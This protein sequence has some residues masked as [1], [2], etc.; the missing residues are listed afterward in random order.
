MK[1]LLTVVR[2][3]EV[4]TALAAGAD[5][6]DVKDPTRGSLG[7]PSP[8]LL[9]EVARRCAGRRPVSLPLGDG[10]HR[11]EEVVPKAGAALTH[12]P[13]YLKVGLA[14][15][16]DSAAGDPAS[17]ARDRDGNRRS[18]E[19]LARAIGSAGSGARLV[20]VTFADAPPG[21]APSPEELV[22]LARRHGADAVMLDTLS[23]DGPSTPEILGA[24]RLERWAASAR[25]LGLETAVAGGLDAASIPRLEGM[26]VD[27]VG[28][29]GGACA[30]GRRGR[31]EARRCRAV[32]RAV[33][34]AST[35]RPAPR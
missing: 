1:L 24:R 22:P 33:D 14:A 12:G 17:G 20:A 19:A 30:G 9:A 35:P 6:V 34:G 23:K 7:P 13:A 29:R 25:S 8:G 21:R 2:R 3:S 4:D 16:P 32:R 5:L 15:G 11:P 26:G 31:L 27:V 10:P 28:V 18:L